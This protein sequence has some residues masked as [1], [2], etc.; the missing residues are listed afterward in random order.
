MLREKLKRRQGKVSK[1]IRYPVQISHTAIHVSIRRQGNRFFVK[2]LLW[3]QFLPEIIWHALPIYSLDDQSQEN[4]KPFINNMN[5]IE[6]DVATIT[7][8]KKSQDFLRKNFVVQPNREYVLSQTNNRYRSWSTISNDGEDTP[9]ATGSS[10][11]ENF[12]KLLKN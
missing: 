11:T 5:V 1:R 10:T 3:C 6:F 4:W 12:K 2:K 9:T 7:D 8:D